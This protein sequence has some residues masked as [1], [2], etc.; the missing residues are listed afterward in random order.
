MPRGE[1]ELCRVPRALPADERL[2]ASALSRA[3]KLLSHICLSYVTDIDEQL[4][5]DQIGT[6]VRAS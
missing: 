5:D 2:P 6:D 3:A 4:D 1:S